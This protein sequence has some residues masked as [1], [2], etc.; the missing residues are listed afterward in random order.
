MQLKGLKANM[1]R[2]KEFAR[3][4]DVPYSTVIFWLNKGALP[5]AEKVDFPVGKQSFF[6][7]VP[8]DAPLPDLPKGPKPKQK[9]EKKAAK[10]GRPKK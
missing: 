6:W 5:G 3:L 8:Q 7:L 10:K 4:H 2:A 1:I 9:T